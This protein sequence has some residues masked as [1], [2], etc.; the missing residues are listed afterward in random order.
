[1]PSH[2]K[3]SAND[4]RGGR[5]DSMKLQE[6]ENNLG[7]LADPNVGNFDYGQEPVI[8]LRDEKDREM[9]KNLYNVV[10]AHNV[11]MDQ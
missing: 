2:R 3:Y 4:I 11:V 5:I 7:S 10:K 6:R 8:D 1:M 9:L